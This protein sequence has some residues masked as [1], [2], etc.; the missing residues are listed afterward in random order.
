MH[1]GLSICG[2]DNQV[3]PRIDDDTVPRALIQATHLSPPRNNIL[4]Q[5]SNISVFHAHTMAHPFHQRALMLAILVGIQA[6]AFSTCTQAPSGRAQT[7]IVASAGMNHGRPHHL[8]SWMSSHALHA[9]GLRPCN[10]PW[11][12]KAHACPTM[13]PAVGSVES[14]L[15][16]RC[17]VLNNG[18]ATAHD[19]TR[20]HI[21]EACFGP[22]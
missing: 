9:E 6:L 12:R 3:S 15:T 7:T 8:S 10:I 17:H 11:C 20:I 18:H 5:R 4:L 2:P 14:L 22:C 1:I 21:T 13:T 16:A 19:S